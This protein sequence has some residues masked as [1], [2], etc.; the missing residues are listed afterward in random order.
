MGV[1]VGVGWVG[2]GVG[3]RV[4]LGCERWHDHEG[5]RAWRPGLAGNPATV[6]PQAPEK[7]E[8]GDREQC[9]RPDRQEQKRSQSATSVAVPCGG[10][11]RAPRRRPA[12][13]PDA[14]RSNRRERSGTSA[15]HCGRGHCADGRPCGDN[16]STADRCH[17]ERRA[18]Q[19]PAAG[20]RRAARAATIRGRQR[21]RP[22]TGTAHPDRVRGP[23]ARAHRWP[24]AGRAPRRSEERA[25][26]GVA[27]GQRPPARVRR[28]AAGP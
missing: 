14:A 27:P 26:R 5:R 23:E 4:G 20:R 22:R 21:S 8:R 18:A 16:A 9:E 11:C 2:V 15:G 3:R 17:V 28:T 1:G 10:T 12:S 24:A 19:R 6:A 13:A 25:G 7:C